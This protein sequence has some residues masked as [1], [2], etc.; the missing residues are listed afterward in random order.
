LLRGIAGG[1]T[2]MVE[3]VLM[4]VVQPV[5]VAAPTTSV[6]P[7]GGAEPADAAIVAQLAPVRVAKPRERSHAHTRTC[8]WDVDD[9]RW[10]C[11]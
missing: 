4:T 3:G 8:Y 7:E 9:C 11:G 10:V 1:V 2:M 6:V 5:G